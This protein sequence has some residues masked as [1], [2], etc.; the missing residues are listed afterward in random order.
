MK[1]DKP[2][3]T[4]ESIARKLGFDPLDPPKLKIAPDEVDD[5]TPSIWAS[6]SVDEFAFVYELR[7]GKKLSSTVYERLK[8][9]ESSRKTPGNTGDGAPMEVYYEN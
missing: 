8:E 4:R 7:T 3:I 5:L 6:L 1:T 9:V 2:E